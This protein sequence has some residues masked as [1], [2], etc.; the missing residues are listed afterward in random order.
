[1]LTLDTEKEQIKET[2][3]GEAQISDTLISIA[4]SFVTLTVPELENAIMFSSDRNDKILFRTLLNLKMQFD[5][6]KII[7]QTLL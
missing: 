1:M 4:E 6:E 5:Q 2:V 7:K 3:S